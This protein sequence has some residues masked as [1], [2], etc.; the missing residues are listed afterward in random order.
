MSPL[1]PGFPE[2]PSFWRPRLTPP[3]CRCLDHADPVQ[4][5]AVDIGNCPHPHRP[6]PWRRYWGDP[7]SNV[8]PPEHASSAAHKDE[9][10][11]AWLTSSTPSLVALAS[12]STHALLATNSAFESF[13]GWKWGDPRTLLNLFHFEEGQDLS[14]ITDEVLR[15]GLPLSVSGRGVR[16]A[17]PSGVYSARILMD[18]TCF[19]MQ[20]SDLKTPAVLVHARMSSNAGAV[21]ARQAPGVPTLPA[22]QVPSMDQD[23]LALA[24]EAVKMGVWE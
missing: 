9:I 16:L 15:S 21:S 18:F 19:P 11:E 2:G 13:F 23:R 1:T 8:P 14:S 12:G 4:R 20:L 22:P 6:V 10:H 17:D 24:L 7:L 3:A 5:A